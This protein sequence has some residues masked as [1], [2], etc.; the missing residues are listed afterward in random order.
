MDNLKELIKQ[1]ENNDSQKQVELAREYCNRG[2]WDKAIYWYKSAIKLGNPDGLNGL[3][4]CYLEGN[5]VIKDLYKARVLFEQAADGGST[6]AICNIANFFEKDRQDE[7]FLKAANLGNEYAQY[8]VGKDWMHGRLSPTS[9]SVIHKRDTIKAFDWFLKS[10]NQGYS[11]AQYEVGLFFEKGTDPC[12]RNVEKALMWYEK[13][14]K[15]GNKKATFA[16]GRLYA[17]GIDDLSPDFE[18]AFYYYKIAADR[19][20]KAAQFRA[21]MALLYGQGVK[22]NKELAYNYLLKAAEKGH[23]E[24][25]IY[26]AAMLLMG[27]GVEKNKGQAKQ[28][29]D[30]TTDKEEISRKLCDLLEYIEESYEEVAETSSSPI[31]ELLGSVDEYGV[32]Y[33]LDGKKLL[34]YSLNDNFESFNFG[35][36]KQQSLNDYIVKDGTEI[37]C[38]NAFENCE[39]IQKIKLPDTIKSIGENAFAHCENLEN[40]NLP[41]GI[42]KL[43][44]YT[45]EGCESLENLTLPST[46]TEIGHNVFIKVHSL[47]SKSDKF[48][49]KDGCLLSRDLKT[50]IHFFNDDRVQFKIPPY[51]ETVGKSAFEGSHISKIEIPS[52]VKSI[53]LCAFAECAELE[54]LIFEPAIRNGQL[55]I[56]SY[57]F[58]NC[59]KLKYVLLSDNVISIGDHAFSQCNLITH[60]EFPYS[61]EE[62]GSYA[63]ENTSLSSVQLPKNLQR[64]GYKPFMMSNIVNIISKSPYF[65]VDEN[66]VYDESGKKLLQYYGRYEKLQIRDGVEEIA[67]YAFVC[68]WSLRMLVIPSSVKRIGRNILDQVV[69]ETLF[70]DKNVYESNKDIIDELSYKNLIF[71]ENDLY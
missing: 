66:I 53:E 55:S 32:L 65:K 17:N 34:K 13:S 15:Q 26:V 56:N 42:T 58:N 27:Y 52:T 64:M 10:A 22:E 60:I 5:G 4:C 30:F 41:E 12:I 51:I 38:D 69:L 29:L 23:Q 39:S 48:I 8:M 14:A 54:I 9:W 37:I 68:A 44:D 6:R 31:E 47:W 28:W 7:L 2:L 59:E 18:K 11:L 40:I 70:I 21:G 57:S 35:T 46:L 49:I 50:L 62:I 61:L 63:F 43:K 24:S 25:K 33:S 1:A 20:L 36:I 3:G 67:D 16:I 71:L 19:G 45:F